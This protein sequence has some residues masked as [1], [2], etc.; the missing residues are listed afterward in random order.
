MNPY[1]ISGKH[2]PSVHSL[3]PPPIHS[4]ALRQCS[5]RLRKNISYVFTLTARGESTCTSTTALLLLQYIYI[6]SAAYI[7]THNARIYIF[8]YNISR[9]CG[10]TI[11]FPFCHFVS[12]CGKHAVFLS[13]QFSNKI[14]V[15]KRARRVCAVCI[16]QHHTRVKGEGG[17]VGRE[18]PR[19][20][21]AKIRKSR[22][23][24]RV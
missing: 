16:L 13:Q 22:R 1:E 20:L 9:V 6:G 14:I 12:V 17:G 21:Y 8:L 3:P 2:V 18:K 10:Y 19:A 15:K 7:N 23:G 5:G 11:Y 24:Q 4:R